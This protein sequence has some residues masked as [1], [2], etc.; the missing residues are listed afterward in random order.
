[1]DHS[2]MNFSALLLADV[3]VEN[4]VPYTRRNEPF[5]SSKPPF[6][7]RRAKRAG[8][9]SESVSTDTPVVVPMDGLGTTPLPALVPVAAKLAEAT[10]NVMELINEKNDIDVKPFAKVLASEVFDFDMGSISNHAHTSKL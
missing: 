9:D 2:R 8:K 4:V 7:N 5:T 1:M 6:G 3:P 10:H